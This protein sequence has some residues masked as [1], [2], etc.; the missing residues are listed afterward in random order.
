MSLLFPKRWK[1]RKQMRWRNK[2]V[3]TRGTYVSYWDFWMKTIDSAYLTNRQIESARKVIVRYVRK[4]WKIW[5]R[6]FPDLPYTKKWLEMPMG[7]WKW[8]VDHYRVRVKRWRVLFE[9]NWVD[10]KTAEEAFKQA[11]YKLPLRIKTVEKQEVR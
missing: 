5:I 11:A 3:S 1:H 10:K 8:E 6:V 9:I 7:K 4:L 2:G